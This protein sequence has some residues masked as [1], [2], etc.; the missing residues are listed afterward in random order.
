MHLERNLVEPAKSLSAG[1]CT[2]TDPGGKPQ[3]VGRA[4]RDSYTA[5]ERLGR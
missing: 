3:H 2:E 1:Q 4:G 5:L